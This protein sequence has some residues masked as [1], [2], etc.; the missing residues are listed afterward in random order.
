MGIRGRLQGVEVQPF[1]VV[2]NL[3]VILTYGCLVVELNPRLDGS[4]FFYADDLIA[5]LIIFAPFA[6]FFLLVDIL[7]GKVWVDHEYFILGQRI[8]WD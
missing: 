7:L 8:L 1:F 5:S 4:R 3:V 2:G 6:G